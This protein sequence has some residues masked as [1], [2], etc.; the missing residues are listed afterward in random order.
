MYVFQE[1]GASERR[2]GGRRRLAGRVAAV[3]L[4]LA[5]VLAAGPA[6]AGA[7]TSAKVRLTKVSPVAGVVGVR[8]QVTLP[9]GVA[10][11]RARVVVSVSGDGAGGK[12]TV[13]L[14]SKRRF[15][16]VLRTGLSGAAVVH[17]RLRVSGKATG[18]EVRRN[19]TLPSSGADTPGTGTAA[20]NG[21]LV[22]LFKVTAGKLNSS[23]VSGSWF[24]MKTPTG[25]YLGNYSSSASDPSYTLFKP[26][27]D[28]GLV[29]G[30]YQAAP[31]PAFDPNG[32]AIAKRILQTEPFFGVQFGVSTNQLD[33]Q[34]QTAVPPPSII[35]TSGKLSG[36]L[37]SWAAQWNT[38]SFNQGSPKP[39][40]SS[41]G[42]TRPV[43]GS[44]DPKTGKYVLE[45][46]SLIVGGPFDTF[47]GEWHLEG[48]FV[49]R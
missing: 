24:R 30:G 45:W 37:S 17:A 42:F 31:T 20:A 4:P 11:S 7:A 14:T 26:G 44:Y 29:T 46:A 15:R 39:D 25:D 27:T 34:T 32:N 47:A 40:G 49:P 35:A 6:T 23:G 21:P 22:G 16:V 8:G 19:V 10:R 28:G 9:S 33:P 43:T 41:T 1:R 2:D 12:E 13:K 18:R 38:Q 36:Q 5:V 3:G 48:T